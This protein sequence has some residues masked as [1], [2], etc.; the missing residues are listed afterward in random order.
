MENRVTE[1]RGQGAEQAA[2]L[3]PLALKPGGFCTQVVQLWH[4]GMVCVYCPG[5]CGVWT[6]AVLGSAAG[7]DEEQ[8]DGYRQPEV[9]HVMSLPQSTAAP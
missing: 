8:R 5:G 1:W 2:S 4:C 6:A 9:S 3:T 7:K